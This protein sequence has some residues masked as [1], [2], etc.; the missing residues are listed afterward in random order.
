MSIRPGTD[1]FRACETRREFSV[2]LA[3]L[4]SDLANFKVTHLARSKVRRLRQ[5]IVAFDAYHRRTS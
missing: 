5:S 1:E 2:V 3:F 4:F